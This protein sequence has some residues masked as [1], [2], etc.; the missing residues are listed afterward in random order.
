MLN[1][2]FKKE[3]P[4]ADN[5]K[6]Q[7]HTLGEILEFGEER[8][9]SAISIFICNPW[10]YMYPLAQ[11]GIDFEEID[12]FQLFITL[13]GQL[14]PEIMQFLFGDT[15][16]FVDARPAL[17]NETGKLTL[18]TPNGLSE[19]FNA[20]SLQGVGDVI[21]EIHQLEPYEEKKP[22]NKA[23]KAYLLEQAAKRARRRKHKKTEPILEPLI[24]ALVNAPEFPYNY[25]TAQEVTIYQ[26]FVSSHQIPRRLSW[27]FIMHGIHV[28]MIDPKNINQAEINWLTPS[29]NTRKAQ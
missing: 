25:T 1:L 3:V 18:V 17:N 24:I 4:C 8:Y 16:S 2:L 7:V 23:A 22:G 21:R 10:D 6:F 13:M 5:I 28:G 27:N 29:R 9:F 26:L 14:N 12:S 20:A 15:L 11:A 19:E